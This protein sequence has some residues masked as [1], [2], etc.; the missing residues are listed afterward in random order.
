MFNE[1][2]MAQVGR[3]LTLMSAPPRPRSAPVKGDLHGKFDVWF[4]GGAVKI[5]TG[6]STYSFQDGATAATGSW[7]DLSMHI[8]LPNGHVVTLTERK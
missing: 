5:D 3:I 7:L 8:T 4:D 2:V 6:V 1:Q